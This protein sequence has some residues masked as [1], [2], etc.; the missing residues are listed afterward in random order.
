MAMNPG[1]VLYPRPLPRDLDTAAQA[2]SPRGRTLQSVEADVAQRMIQEALVRSGG[3]K[4]A[5]ARELGMTEQTLRYR[6]R[7]YSIGRTRRYLRPRKN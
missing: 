5:A 1:S 6:L 7:K 3:N 2:R 4:T